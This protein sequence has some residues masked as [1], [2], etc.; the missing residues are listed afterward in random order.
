MAITPLPSL[1]RTSVN[2]KADVDTF[3][4]S[5]LP[6]FSTEAEAARADIVIKQGQ[7]ATS[8][9][10]AATSEGNALTSKNAAATSAT[11]AA[12]SATNAATSATNAATSEANALTSKNDAATSAT[13]AATSAASVVRDGSGGVAGL[14]LFKIN[15]KNA[16]NTFTS[17]F[18]NAN[19]AA[20]TY[21]FQDRNGTVA[22]N[23]DLALKA[24]LASPAFTGVPAVPTA[25]ALDNT[26][27]AAS[28]AFV[29]ANSYRKNNIL[30]TV[31]QSAGVPTGAVIERGSNAN[32]EY[33]RFADGTQICNFNLTIGG[34]S[35]TLGS[36][37]TNSSSTWTYPA[38]FMVSGVPSIKVDEYGGNGATWAGLGGGATG[39]TSATFQ[40]F[41]ATAATVASQVSLSAIGRW[42]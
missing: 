25:A 30:G 28:T 9:T 42:F 17:F 38:A 29:L 37:F 21:T 18:T 35:T 10:N 14:T 1:D 3:F 22:D 23:T 27:Q 24:N 13:N 34:P 33:V 12:T 39:A 20:R 26:T 8:A 40:I 5:Q 2:F 15:F 41:K 7:A 32:G 6:T 4:G 16:L 31:S 11:N 19:T 36:I